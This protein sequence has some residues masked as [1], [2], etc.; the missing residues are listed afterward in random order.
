MRAQIQ[1][2]PFQEN[3]FS[4]IKN[5]DANCL[6]EA[7]AG[8]GKSTTLEHAN[9]LFDP[10]VSVIN[11]AFNKHIAE[12]LRARLPFYREV[13]TLNSIFWKVC[14]QNVRN[15][16]VNSGKNF[17]YL[18]KHFN[19][20]NTEDSKVFWKIQ[21]QVQRIV[22]L[23]K[24]LNYQSW[25]END[26]E[27]IASAYGVE[28]VDFDKEFDYWCE[29]VYNWSIN[30]PIR[31]G[32]F[33]FTDQMFQV[34]R[35]NW[36]IL[37]RDVCFIDEAQD[38]S[39]VQIELVTRLANR[40]IA[41]GDP[42]QAIYVFRG[43]D[44]EAIPNLLKRIDGSILP[45]SVSYRCPKSVINE[46]KS[47]VPQI[48]AAPNAID[49]HVGT[50]DVGEYWDTVS[51]ISSESDLVLCRTTA[52]LVTKC[53]EGFRNHS[54]KGFVRGRDIGMNICKLIDKIRDKMGVKSD[55]V[56]HLVTAVQEYR[57]DRLAILNSCGKFHEAQAL[58]D[59]I[60]T[61]VA[62]ANYPS[63]RE[64]K[65]AING[66]FSD[67]AEGV[68]YSTIHRAKGRERRNVFTIRGDLLPHPRTPQHLLQIEYNL[69]YVRDTRSQVNLIRVVE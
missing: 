36:R 23:F 48:E 28:T 50:I 38:L 34:V 7:V 4:F 9:S 3:I 12:A 20:D 61:I 64:V 2:S 56:N 17:Y 68:E 42:N 26:W 47:I 22:D 44:V 66:I 33:D 16:R 62:F 63:V 13:G 10:T 14:R 52:P 21:S 18:Q 25:P 45:L 30:D 39:P 35:H 37:E 46:V 54:M 32:D 67:Q 31:S 8:S 55:K 49:G 69:M 1:W 27:S 24:Q 58:D 53:L 65:E 51:R 11:C 40:V 59:N 15:A 5:E 6:V 29:K 19:L 41:V 57:S 43:A 60:E